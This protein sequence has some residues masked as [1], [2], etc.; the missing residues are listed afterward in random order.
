MTKKGKQE[1][2]FDQDL[3]LAAG[4]ARMIHQWA[5]LVL[6]GRD[7]WFARRHEEV[8]FSAKPISNRYDVS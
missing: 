7:I 8:M 2:W 4:S 1:F 3:R 5:G 6:S